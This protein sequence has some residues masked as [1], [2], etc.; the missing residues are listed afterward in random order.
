LNVQRDVTGLG[1]L[2]THPGAISLDSANTRDMAPCLLCALSLLLA[3]AGPARAQTCYN[4][5]VFKAKWAV[6]GADFQVRSVIPFFSWYTLLQA[7]RTYVD[8]LMCRCCPTSLKQTSLLMS[9]LH[10]P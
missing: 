2:R 10:P 1:A 6:A 7:F 3:L 5:T 8:G 9:S 4:R